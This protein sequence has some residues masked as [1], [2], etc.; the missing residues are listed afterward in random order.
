M[1]KL[2]KRLRSAIGAA[3]EQSSRVL[4]PPLTA[5]AGPVE[6]QAAILECVERE[7][8]PQRDGRRKLPA[9]GLTVTVLV[10]AGEK[11]VFQTG[12]ADLEAALIARLTEIG[13]E[14]R[15]A[16]RAVTTFVSRRPAKW[17]PTQRFAIAWSASASASTSGRGQPALQVTV[18]RGKA[19]RASYV[20]TEPVIRFGRTEMPV[21]D[22]GTIRHNQVA[23]VENE[24]NQAVGRGHCRVEFD[25]SS[26][27]YRVFDEG[28]ANRTSLVR[29][30]AIIPVLPH[31]P[32]GIVIVSGDE[33]RLGSAAVRLVIA[34]R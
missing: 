6:V 10:D 25:R 16:F 27:S 4:N 13:C 17:Q 19:T 12:L 2:V 20:L 23:F 29:Y 34:A 15:P 26:G 24:H 31:D 22:E 5:D 18:L 11:P 14:I 3:V 30:G 7:T 9:D 33:L 1:K 21:D 32:I 28:S 8:Q